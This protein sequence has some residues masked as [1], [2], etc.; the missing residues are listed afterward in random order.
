MDKRI[1]VVDSNQQVGAATARVL[2]DAQYDTRFVATFGEALG[3]VTR[4]CPDLVITAVRLGHYNGIHLALRCRLQCPDVPVLIMGV[5]SDAKLAD[6]ASSMDMRFAL[7]PPTYAAL[8]LLVR[9]ALGGDAA[10]DG[11]RPP[12]DDPDLRTQFKP[13]P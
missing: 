7:R 4:Q 9:E 1:L 12:A 5:G 11:E 10:S 13:K 3:E 8:L 2:A 6:D